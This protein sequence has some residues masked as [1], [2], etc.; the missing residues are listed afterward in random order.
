MKIDLTKLNSQGY[1]SI[2]IDP[3]GR[4]ES[5]D[6]TSLAQ[7]VQYIK[8]KVA[9]D[10]VSAVVFSPNPVVAGVPVT[11]R[12]FRKMVKTK[13]GRVFPRYSILEKCGGGSTGA[14]E[15]L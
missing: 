11:Y 8:A 9:P 4:W 7:M 10:K 15:R 13:T 3:N 2:V 14:H 12:L 1:T 5:E 6:P